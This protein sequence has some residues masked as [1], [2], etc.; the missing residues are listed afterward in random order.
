MLRESVGQN[1][2]QHAGILLLTKAVA[3]CMRGPA[4]LYNTTVTPTTMNRHT[5]RFFFSVCCIYTCHANLQGK[6]AAYLL[7][8]MDTR[9]TTPTIRP[10]RPPTL[11]TTAARHT[12][13]LKTPQSA[14]SAAST[15]P[16]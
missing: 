7:R 15:L 13:M 10:T 1:L 6:A 2:M 9:P 5:W 8:Q 12:L 14:V 3:F 4:T 16:T 11:S